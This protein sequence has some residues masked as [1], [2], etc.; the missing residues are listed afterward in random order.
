MFE[1][2][3]SN[4]FEICIKHL[5]GFSAFLNFVLF[6]C[7]TLFT[8]PP[9]FRILDR[10]WCP[11]IALDLCRSA[12]VRGQFYFLCFTSFRNISKDLQSRGVSGWVDCIGETNVSLFQILLRK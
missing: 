8:T 3:F 2:F 12:D 9:P 10:K 11:Q 4:F 5:L 7:K 6:F 1:N